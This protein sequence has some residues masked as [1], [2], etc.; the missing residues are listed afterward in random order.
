MVIFQLCCIT[1]GYE[2][3]INHILTIDQPH[4]DHRSTIFPHFP[5]D[6]Q[7]MPLW[8]ATD[9]QKSQGLPSV[10]ATED[11][12]ED[13]EASPG[14]RCFGGA[15]PGRMGKVAVFKVKEH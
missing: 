4:I 7:N 2:P 12:Q 8:H 13:R 11:Q 1:R 15:A 3:Y 10:Q 6:F 9:L 14:G 5:W